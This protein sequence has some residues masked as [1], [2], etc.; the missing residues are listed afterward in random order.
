MK[1][2]D[3]KRTSLSKQP[4]WSLWLVAAAFIFALCPLASATGIADRLEVGFG[5]IEWDEFGLLLWHAIVAPIVAAV[6]CIGVSALAGHSFAR[7]KAPAAKVT[8]FAVAA[9]GLFV[10]M[11]MCCIPLFDRV[12]AARAHREP[13]VFI[14]LRATLNLPIAILV[15]TEFFRG[16]PAEVEDAAMLDGL[17]RVQILLRIILPLSAPAL[18]ATGILVFVGCSSEVL[19]LVALPART[20]GHSAAV[21]GTTVYTSLSL[22]MPALA[23]LVMIFQRRL[24]RNLTT[25]PAAD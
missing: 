19:W 14:V 24:A 5:S 7:L 8:L 6:L 16:I 22:M 21:P 10:P 2:T 13:I 11:F 4:R 17:G 23:V 3:A 18:A 20:V 12:L 9:L 1:T 25:G 15:L